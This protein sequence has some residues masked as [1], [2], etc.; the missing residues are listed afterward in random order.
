LRFENNEEGMFL[1]KEAKKRAEEKAKAEK[2]KPVV[3]T[4]I[5]DAGDALFYPK[6]GDTLSVHYIGRVQRDG[7]VFDNSYDRGQTI[8]FILGAK[9]VIPGWEEVLPNMCRGQKVIATIPPE[10]AYGQKGYP[11]L[12]PPHAVLE[13]EIELVS[14]SSVGTTENLARDNNYDPNKIY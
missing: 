7:T 14:F 4:K 9:Q 10:L 1:S 8:Y 12:I 3:E 6:V 13:Y 5:I 2:D 11:P